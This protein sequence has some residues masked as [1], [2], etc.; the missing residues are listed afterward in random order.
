MCPRYTSRMKNVLEPLCP[1][2]LPIPLPEVGQLATNTGRPRVGKT[3]R[4]PAKL[5]AQGPA[6]CFPPVYLF[7]H[8]L[9]H[10]LALRG[11]PWRSVAR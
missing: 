6:F 1:S 9:W 5:R 8:F 10:V 4:L 11:A 3:S 7:L 2:A